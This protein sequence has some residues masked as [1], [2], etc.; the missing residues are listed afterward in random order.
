MV[1]E[2]D[3][4]DQRQAKTRNGCRSHVLE[5]CV[6]RM[7]ILFNCS[8]HD[9]SGGITIQRQRSVH[10]FHAAP[11][12]SNEI[13]VVQKAFKDHTHHV[14][15]RERDRHVCRDLVDFFKVFPNDFARA[16]LTRAGRSATA[17]QKLAME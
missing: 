17:D 6:R 2:P 1:H 11:H 4:R 16:T 14:E 13:L 8:R 3:E 5:S 7:M 10:P 9:P 15:D 12:G